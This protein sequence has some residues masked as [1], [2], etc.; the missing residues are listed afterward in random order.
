MWF[1]LARMIEECLVL[2][3]EDPVFDEQ[4]TSRKYSR[5]KVNGK[6]IVESK[7]EM[8]AEGMRSPDRVDAFVLSLHGLTVEDFHEELRKGNSTTVVPSTQAARALTSKEL[9]SKPPQR[10]QRRMRAQ[11]MGEPIDLN[12]MIAEN[13][14]TPTFMSVLTNLIQHARHN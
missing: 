13:K 7:R 1:N 12:E 9:L 5:S 6:M 8:K 2:L 14:P 10:T 4:L 3:P 11:Q